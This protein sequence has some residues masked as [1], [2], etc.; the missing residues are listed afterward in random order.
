MM[1]AATILLV[2][3]ATTNAAAGRNTHQSSSSSST[4]SSTAARRVGEESSSSS[5]GEPED[6]GGWLVRFPRALAGPSGGSQER[7]RNELYF[8]SG[9]HRQEHHHHHWRQLSHEQQHR[10]MLLLQQQQSTTHERRRH[11]SHSLRGQNRGRKRNNRGLEEDDD[12]AVGELGWDDE[13]DADE[14]GDRDCDDFGTSGGGGYFNASS[15]IPC[16]DDPSGTGGSDI[17]VEGEQ[18]SYGSP[19]PE[20][21]GGGGGGSY[22]NRLDNEVWLRV[23][24]AFPPNFPSRG[25]LVTEVLSVFL[26]DTNP[27]FWIDMREDVRRRRRQRRG[28]QL[29]GDDDDDD[30]SGNGGGGGNGSGGSGGGGN[31][32]GGNGGGQGEDGQGDGQDQDDKGDSNSG[33]QGNGQGSG[34][35][36]D[37]GNGGSNSGGQGNGGSN[38][39]GQGDGQ[40]QDDKG[41]SISNGQGN[42]QDQD[43]KADSNSSGQGNG[44]DQDDKADS[45]SSGQGN[46]QDQDDKADSNGSGQSD[47]EGQGD[48]ETGNGADQGDPEDDHDEDDAEDDHDED[49]AED[50]PEDD[51]GGAQNNVNGTD[52]GN[53][54]DEDDASEDSSDDDAVAKNDDAW[55]LWHHHTNPELV[56]QGSWW[57]WQYDISF[58]C[59]SRENASGLVAVTDTSVLTTVHGLLDDALQSGMDSGILYDWMTDEY[60]GTFGAL[61]FT[62][63]YDEIASDASSTPLPQTNQVVFSAYIAFPPQELAR[64]GLVTDFLTL[65][66][67]NMTTEYRLFGENNDTDIAVSVESQKVA[68]GSGLSLRD[69]Q[70]VDRTWDMYHQNTYSDLL[71]K[72][73]IWWWEYDLL[74]RCYWSDTQQPVTNATALD[75]AASKLK[76]IVDQGLSTGSIF[77]WLQ[78]HYDAGL[79]GI[80]N[81]TTD[82]TVLGHHNSDSGSG[83]PSEFMSEFMTPL[84]PNAWD[85]SRYLGLG[86]FLGTV[87]VT[88]VLMQ[89]AT[90]R[91]RALKKQ[92][93]WGSLGTERGVDELLKTGWKIKGSHM[94]I[95][96]KSKLGYDDDQGSMLIGGFEQREAAAIGA[97]ITVTHPES[98]TINTPE[99]HHYSFHHGTS[100]EFTP[101]DPSPSQAFQSSLP[102]RSDAPPE[103]RLEI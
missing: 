78:D 23:Y 9:K 75:H 86:L 27:N 90:Y 13:D 54:D 68:S 84:D 91:H 6:E 96:D 17:P 71:R 48:S 89:L 70:L 61:D 34:Q 50:D 74:F 88:F 8:G 1:A 51:V 57:W 97:E 56:Q 62:T 32:G 31:D 94:E 83:D 38:S 69:R 55:V 12:A 39:G 10:P 42:G 52:A 22:H 43:D 77:T 63:N 67:S 40:D 60:E 5:L 72:G 20:G 82:P 102:N 92:E 47:G 41:E 24:V 3:G 45:N 46:G 99:T 85:L 53:D 76:Q 65:Y 101:P 28:R 7:R 36:S 35:G 21:G 2:L 49:D 14:K 30:G 16:R 66:I 33:N 64:R 79:L 80:V 58:E 44:Q 25:A 26:N 98:E 93:M 81:M 95:Y 15:P 103:K 37:Q 29:E 19:P 4:S 73:P 11:L 18:P 87:V 59:F 100:S